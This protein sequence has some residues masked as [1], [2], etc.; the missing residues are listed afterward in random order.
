MESK[1]PT[2]KNCLKNVLYVPKK[3]HDYLKTKF[4]YSGM[5]AD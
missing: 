4:L 5:T 1:W 2:N 3:A